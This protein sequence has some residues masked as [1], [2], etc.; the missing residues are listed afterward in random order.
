MWR[1]VRLHCIFLAKWLASTRTRGKHVVVARIMVMDM[2]QMHKMCVVVAGERGYRR[3]SCQW[4]QCWS[5]AWIFV[6]GWL[7]VFLG[8]GLCKSPDKKGSHTRMLHTAKNSRLFSRRSPLKTEGHCQFVMAT[9]HDRASE[10]ERTKSFC[11][12]SYTT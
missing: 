7:S 10:S 3:A 4:M 1:N 6:P 9:M 11:F 8:S 5:I 2:G 12:L